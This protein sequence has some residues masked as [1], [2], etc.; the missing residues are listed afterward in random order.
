MRL[1]QLEH[2]F[3]DSAKRLPNR[4]DKNHVRLLC[5]RRR[6]QHGFVRCLCGS[7]DYSLEYVELQLLEDIVQCWSR[8]LQ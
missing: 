6:M 4:L 8:F 5:G 7:R 1:G 2:R 3:L